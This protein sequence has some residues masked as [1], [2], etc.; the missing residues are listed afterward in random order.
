MRRSLLLILSILAIATALTVAQPTARAQGLPP[1]ILIALG[2]AAGGFG[3]FVATEAI[4][5]GGL[6]DGPPVSPS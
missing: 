4:S 2:V 1:G 3:I 5:D 6:G